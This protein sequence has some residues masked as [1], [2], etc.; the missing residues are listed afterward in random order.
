MVGNSVHRSP[1]LSPY[2]DVFRDIVTVEEVKKFKPHPV[3]YYHLA[4]K[5]GKSKEQM[6]DMWL[7]SGNPFDVVG[8]KAVG[9]KA[10]WVDRGHQGWSDGL[11]DGEMGAPDFIGENLGQIVQAILKSSK[12]EG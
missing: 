3:V 4:M 6:G 5:V 10:C 1:D 7:V 8:A 9:M 12:T 11:V 2:S